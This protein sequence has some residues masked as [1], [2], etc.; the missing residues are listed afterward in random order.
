MSSKIT[1]RLAVAEDA[2]QIMDM[3][4]ELAIYE[5]MD[6]MLKITPEFLEHHIIND[7]QNYICF[8]AENSEKQLVGYCALY[9]IFSLFL[10]A[11]GLHIHDLYVRE[12]HRGNG[13][14]TNFFKEIAKLATEQNYE[15]ITWEALNWNKSAIDFYKKL[16]ATHQ[17]EWDMFKL[18]GD[19]IKRLA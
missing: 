10:G 3:I 13:I 9:K 1:I 6:N 15:R 14:G 4:R 5:K 7:G 18:E 8:V 19:T 12:E 11:E 2:P 16:G 17:A